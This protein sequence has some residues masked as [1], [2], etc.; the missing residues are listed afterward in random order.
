[1]TKLEITRS[2][3]GQRVDALWAILFG[4]VHTLQPFCEGA[5]RVFAERSLHPLQKRDA[6]LAAIA[7]AFEKMNGWRCGSLRHVKARRNEIDTAIS[8]LRNRAIEQSIC[9]LKIAPSARN[10]AGAFRVCLATSV[11]E[12][13]DSQ[14][15]ELIAGTV[16]DIAAVR[17]LFPF[18]FGNLTCFHPG[19]DVSSDFDSFEV[20]LQHAGDAIGMQD[21]VNSLRQEVGRI[22]EAL[23]TPT[24]LV[25]PDGYWTDE[26]DGADARLRQ[27]SIA[28]FHRA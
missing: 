6:D 8:F 23:D 2:L 17:T 16:Y 11:R 13:N 22:V 28:A 7:G 25:F 24:P 20:M 4:Q 15:P 19:H 9:G 18:D 14:L 27:A 21:E 3:V 26:G 10:A 12:Y 1:M 5:I